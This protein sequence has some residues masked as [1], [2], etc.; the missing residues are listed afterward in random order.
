M[1]MLYFQPDGFQLKACVFF[2]LEEPHPH[3]VCVLVYD[4][5]AVAETMWRGDIHKTPK[6][7]GHV[8]EGTGWFRASS[9]VAGCGSGLMEQA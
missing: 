6:D 2:G 1:Q 3:I 8:Q 4:E 7:R 5:Q 9:G